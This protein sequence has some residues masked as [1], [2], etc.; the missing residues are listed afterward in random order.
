MT[1]TTSLMAYSLRV[2]VAGGLRGT[3]RDAT[4]F[5]NSAPSAATPVAAPKAN[6]GRASP[7]DDAGPFLDRW[8]IPC[9]SVDESLHGLRVAG[10]LHRDGGR[11]GLDLVQVGGGEFEVG[12]GE[13]LLKP[14]ELA[15]AGDRDDPRLLREEPG[16]RD[17]GRGGIQ[18][19]GD[20]RDQVD[21]GLVRCAGTGGEPR[22]AVAEVACVECCRGVDRAGEES[23]AQRAE[24]DEPD[25]ELRKRRDD[26]GL[27]GPPPQRVLRLQRGHRL[28]GV[29]A[30]DRA[31]R[32][33]GHAEVAHL[34][35]LDQLA[36]GTG[37]VLDRD[38]GVD[39]VLVEQV[40]VVGAQSSQRSFH[41]G[42]DVRRAAGQASL[43]AVVVER[44]AELRGD[45]D[46]VAY[47]RE[48]LADDLLVGERAVHL[49]GVEE[50]DAPVDG[51]ADERDA[52]L[53]GGN[54]QVALAQA[55]AAVADGRDLQP[56]AERSR[57]HSL[58]LFSRPASYRGS[59]RMVVARASGLVMCAIADIA[60]WYLRAYSASTAGS[61]SG[62][63]A[64]STSTQ[65]TSRATPRASIRP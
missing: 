30:A 44:E 4:I 45:D 36:H 42:P 62:C 1:T 34:A 27:R 14:G 39:A 65:V 3:R 26:L 17:L 9:L 28:H 15:G 59:T 20:P 25:A 48:R 6:S 16:Q 41:R 10:A 24:R 53:A 7:D 19:P 43:P 49:S 46:L 55:H 22:N 2:G 18:P 31:G 5:R 52:L 57:V 47:W 8:T 11:G 32:G 33:L 61:T 64:A 29:G 21:H 13:V 40:D 54:G 23:L 51:G 50:G 37:G 12:G 35:G 60:P 38:A 58:L 56:A 63:P